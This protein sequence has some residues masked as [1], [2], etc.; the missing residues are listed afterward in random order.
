MFRLEVA[1]EG[2]RHVE[3]HRDRIVGRLEH[4]REVLESGLSWDKRAVPD[5]E[6]YE[7]WR[8]STDEAVEAAERVLANRGQ[9]GIHLD[10]VARRGR[11]P[12]SGGLAGAQGA[13]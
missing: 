11:E 8:E 6:R 2:R 5:R 3:E 1:E 10:G 13:P 9:Y 12:L 7:A 4:S